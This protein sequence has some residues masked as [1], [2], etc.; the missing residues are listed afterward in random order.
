MNSLPGFS[1]ASGCSIP[2]SVATMKVSDSEVRAKLSMPPVDSMCVRSGSTSPE[3]TYS[4]T[5]VVQPHSGWIMNSAPGWADRTAEMSAGRMPACTWHS[6]SHT[7]MRLP[8]T[9]ST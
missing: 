8:I 2:V 7:C 5:W 9:R 4:I 6:P 1:L 3:A